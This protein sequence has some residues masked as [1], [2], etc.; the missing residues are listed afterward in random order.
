[1]SRRSAPL[2]LVALTLALA[3]CAAA[4]PIARAH[5][6][7]AKPTREIVRLQGYRT[8]AP[9]GVPVVHETALVALNESVPFAVVD[10]RT[11]GFSD[12]AAAAPPSVPARLL[13]QGERPLLRRATTARA[14][15]RVTI[16]AERRPGSA[17]LFVLSVDRCPEE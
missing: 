2:P 14:G 16:L 3:L 4:A 12:S 15:Q 11:F 6:T 7:D 13:L 9:A 1:M 5:T 8:P 10:W 17:D